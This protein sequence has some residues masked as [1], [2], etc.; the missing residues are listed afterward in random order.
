MYRCVQNS[1]YSCLWFFACLWSVHFSSFPLRFNIWASN[2]RT[3]ER[4]SEKKWVTS[5]THRADNDNET[6]SVITQT[7][8]AK[9]SCSSRSDKYS[10]IKQWQNCRL[11]DVIVAFAYMH[12]MEMLV[13]ATA[14]T[15]TNTYSF[16]KLSVSFCTTNCKSNDVLTAAT[17][18]F[19]CCCCYW[20]LA[21]L[22]FCLCIIFCS[23]FFSPDFFFQL[24][25][26]SRVS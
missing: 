7:L 18:Y 3:Y 12:S 26:L 10:K 21:G 20:L 17:C 8:S 9:E 19:Y 22:F 5:D 24:L 11:C 14:H 16:R 13:Y 1:L 4:A 23:R 6:I 25:M 15:H 2:E